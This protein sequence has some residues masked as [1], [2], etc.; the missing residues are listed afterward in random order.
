MAPRRSACQRG[1]PRPSVVETLQSPST[2]ASSFNRVILHAK[3]EADSARG[4]TPSIHCPAA[5]SS[6]TVSLCPSRLYS[7][8]LQHHKSTRSVAATARRVTLD[9]V[10]RDRQTRKS[11]RLQGRRGRRE[12]RRG[13]R[14]EGGSGGRAGRTRSR[15]C[16]SPPKPPTPPFRPAR[17]YADSFS[18]SHTH[19]R[20]S[21]S[22]LPLPTYM[23][24][25]R[26]HCIPH[27]DECHSGPTVPL[28]AAAVARVCV[29]QL[30]R[31]REAA[32]D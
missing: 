8:L 4:P 11:T 9:P 15:R 24:T 5:N 17:W 3:P 29:V 2:S 12:E 13:D 6:M 23:A 18:H 25:A 21:P 19:A 14:K 32:D 20:I 1:P 31:V 30:P 28:A 10:T 7:N 22:L 27:A 26:S 16:P